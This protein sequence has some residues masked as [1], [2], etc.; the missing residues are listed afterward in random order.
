MPSAPR[1]LHERFPSSL[2]D[3][4]AREAGGA[5]SSS[6][7][8]EAAAEGSDVPVLCYQAAAKEEEQLE[9]GEYDLAL[10]KAVTASMEAE[11]GKCMSTRTTLQTPADH[12]A[13]WPTSQCWRPIHV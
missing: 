8:E 6:V 9:E 1:S 3:R 4:D 7:T 12:Y 13:S 11:A 5:A 10:L 2:S